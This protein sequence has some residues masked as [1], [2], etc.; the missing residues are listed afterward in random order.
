[1]AAIFEEGTVYNN[2]PSTSEELGELLAQK[3]AE[4]RR[5]CT[6]LDQD[7]LLIEQVQK[8]KLQEEMESVYD[9][10]RKLRKKKRTRKRKR[11]TKRKRRK[12]TRKRRKRKT[13]RRR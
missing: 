5:I 3:R 1:M 10:G 12:K 6:T 8:Q 2:L 11:K 4:K 9:G 7:I 13:E